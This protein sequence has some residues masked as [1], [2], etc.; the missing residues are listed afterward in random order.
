MLLT[1][2]KCMQTTCGLHRTRRLLAGAVILVLGGAPAAAQQGPD[3]VSTDALRVCADPN[4]LPYSN[5]RREGFENKIAEIIAKDLGRP[6][7]YVWF[8]QVV[9]FVR[10]T[11][12][13]NECDLVMGAVAGDE[14][15]ENT[16]T[17][18][19][20][21]YMLV[22]RADA[23]IETNSLGSPALADKKIG[24][25]AATPPTALLLKHDLMDH[26]TSYSLVVDTRF[27]AP[28]HRMIQDI[29]DG[30]LDV[31]VIW[32]PIAGYYIK[33][34]HLPLKAVFIA[35]EDNVRLDFRVAM[36]LR[37]NEADWRRRVNQ[38]IEHHRDEI[39]RILAEYG[40]PQ[41]DEQNQ[42][43]PPAAPGP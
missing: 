28:P 20:S 2:L 34:D 30:K 18:Y 32:G 11:L 23:G 22:S 43:I 10:N 26:V 15:M 25:V 40:I 38:A 24:L 3:L 6:L 12:R 1:H 8:P 29:L 31:G 42:P 35:P 13:K 27:D 36:G 4:D 41:L 16:N 39:A 37:A 14:V 9:G 21:G 19:H 17:Y 33:H 5:D 7:T